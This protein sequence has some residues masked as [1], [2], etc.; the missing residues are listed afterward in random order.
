MGLR[1][2]PYQAVQV[3]SVA[4]EAIRGKRKDP[5]NIY[6]W[7][8][9]RLHLPGSDGY[10]PRKPWVSK[11]RSEDGKIAADLFIFTYWPKSFGGMVSGASGCQH[12]QLFS[13]SRCP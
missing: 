1:S 13:N 4:E 11:I 8:Y 3:M 7:D 2:L 9:V 6:R 12:A 10:D 5:N